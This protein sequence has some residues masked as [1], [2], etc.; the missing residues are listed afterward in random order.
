MSENKTTQTSYYSTPESLA[1]ASA[2]GQ[3]FLQADLFKPADEPR[4]GLLIVHG[5][6]DHRRRYHEVAV[7]FA[8]RGA[9]VLTYDQAGHGDSAPDVEHYGFFAARDGASLVI[10]DL[11]QMLSLF[12]DRYPELPL[13]I[14]A[15]SMGSLIVRDYLTT[16]RQPLA[17][18]ILTGTSG[19]VPAVKLMIG[20]WL[21]MY[22]QHK[23]G[24]KYRSTQ[25]D[26]ILHSGYLSRVP[27]PKTE[28]DWLTRDPEVVADYIADPACGYIFTV[29][30]MLDLTV[31]TERINQPSWAGQVAKDLPLLLASGEQDPVGQ[32]SRGVRRVAK[33]L[34]AA[35]CRVKTIIYPQARHEILNET[36]RQMVYADLDAWISETV[37]Q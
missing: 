31:W 29:S 25:I 7:W 24:P 8:A 19:P 14:L 30:A 20:R 28:F 11:D 12:R 22:A 6:A 33:M 34:N 27:H 2:T 23:F 5:M 13:V 4:F 16:I 36:N 17:G 18:V 1:V 35:G 26:R 32:F 37:L 10:Q 3:G 9:V 21:A 15:H